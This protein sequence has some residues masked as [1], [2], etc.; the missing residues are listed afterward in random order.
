MNCGL[1]RELLVEYIENTIDTLERIMV[2]QHIK[3]CDICKE[4]IR[5]FRALEDELTTYD[6]TYELPNSMSNMCEL[7]VDNLIYMENYEK[8][9]VVKI[10]IMKTIKSIY[11]L[12]NTYKNNPYNRKINE[13]MEKSINSIAAPIKKRI[14]ESVKFNK[15][16]KSKNKKSLIKLFKIV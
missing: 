3:N 15:R 12:A 4:E 2:E 8:E 11:L 1:D 14:K 6:F 7:L 10:N 16:S 13:G 9:D 5:T